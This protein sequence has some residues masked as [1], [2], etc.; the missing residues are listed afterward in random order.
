MIPFRGRS[1][2]KVKMKNKPISEGYKVWELADNGY[3]WDWLWHSHKDGPE[4]IPKKGLIGVLQKVSQGP[5]T[6]DLKP[7][8]ALV[9]RL[10]MHL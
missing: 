4:T 9:I 8:S 10:A 1:L 2:H 6:D 5:K 3:V 7:T